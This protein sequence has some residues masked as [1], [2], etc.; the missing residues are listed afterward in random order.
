MTKPPVRACLDGRGVLWI[1]AA[2]ILLATCTLVQADNIPALSLPQ[3]PS[4]PGKIPPWLIQVDSSGIDGQA[5]RGVKITV[6]ATGPLTQDHSLRV[7][8][9]PNGHS[10]YS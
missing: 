6:A 2:V 3:P 5:F 4:R 8:L 1:C 9:C 10:K 7:V